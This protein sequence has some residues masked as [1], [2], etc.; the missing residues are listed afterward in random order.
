MSKFF[1]ALEQADRD[2][3]LGVSAAPWPVESAVA[4]P[5]PASPRVSAEP[6]ATAI[7]AASQAV[8]EHLVSLVNPTSIAA[9]QYRTLRHVV[10]RAHVDSGL[11]VL[12]ISSPGPR[13]GKTLTAINLAGALA[14]SAGTRV[15]VVD[16]DLRHPVMASYLA[17]DDTG[18]GLAEAILNPALALDRVVQACPGFNLHAIPARRSLNATYE[19]LASRRCQELIQEARQRYEYVIVDLPPLV[20]IPDCQIVQKWVDGMVVVVA[21]GQTP[22]KLLASALAA[23]T[24]SKIVGLVFNRDVGAFSTYAYGNAA[25]VPRRRWFRR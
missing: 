11:R 13:D 24:P 7:P 9:E 23:V 4:A 14:Q 25:E 1:E 5:V 2:R 17:L 6:R 20:P 19:L 8:D 15:L 21:A 10:E 18:V 22:R 12:G 16:M 3:A